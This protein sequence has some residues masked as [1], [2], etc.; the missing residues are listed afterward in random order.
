MKEQIDVI[1]VAMMQQLGVLILSACVRLLRS[2]HF[3]FVQGVPP[4]YQR[5][6]L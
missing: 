1:I 4:K 2:R 6:P 3:G 5:M